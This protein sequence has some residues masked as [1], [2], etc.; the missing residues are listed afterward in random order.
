MAE[1][2]NG[3]QRDRRDSKKRRQQVESYFIN[4][5]ARVCALHISHLRLE[6]QQLTSALAIIGM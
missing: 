3:Q 1:R 2:H 6:H 5:L 4:A